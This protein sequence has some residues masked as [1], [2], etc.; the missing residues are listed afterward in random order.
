MKQ[1]KKVRECPIDLSCPPVKYCPNFEQC[2]D[3]SHS[4]EIP[5]ERR[6]DGLYVRRFAHRWDKYGNLYPIHDYHGEEMQERILEEWKNYGFL[7]A[8]S[9]N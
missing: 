1:I 4:W 6:K 3:L 5:Y 2:Y 7:A 8:V 9:I